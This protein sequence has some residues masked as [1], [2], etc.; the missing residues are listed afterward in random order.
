MLKPKDGVKIYFYT[1]FV[2]MRKSV[3]GLS[4]IVINEL[5][6]EPSNGSVY[7][8]CN[9]AH[10][11]V[12]ILFYDRNGFVLYYK[13]M[14]NKKFSKIKNIGLNYKEISFEQLDW[15][16][17]FG[18]IWVILRFSRYVCA[19]QLKLKEISL[20]PQPCLSQF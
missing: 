2:D 3:N 20:M 19:W 18:V 12:K 14:N 17:E 4:A 13:I 8:F 10:N 5:K 7:I 9:R 16:G 1:E 15:L 6:L 11:K